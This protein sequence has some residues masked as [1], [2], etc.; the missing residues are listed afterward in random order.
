[1]HHA[2]TKLNT[3]GSL[4]SDQSVLCSMILSR[5]SLNFMLFM[6]VASQPLLRNVLTFCAHSKE[7]VAQVCSSTTWLDLSCTCSTGLSSNYK[8]TL[9]GTLLN[10]L[11][12]V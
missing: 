8:T 7:A 10:D 5:R 1:M 2:L 6:Y 9:T 11:L 12:F 3:S 4:I